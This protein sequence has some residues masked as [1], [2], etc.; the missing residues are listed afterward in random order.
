M[1]LP[2]SIVRAY[3]R[4]VPGAVDASQTYGGI[5]FPCNAKAP[6]FVFGVGAARIVIPAKIMAY[7]PVDRGSSMCFGGLQ[8]SGQLGV[9]IFGDTALKAAFV[10]FDASD[11]PAIGWA[12]KNLGF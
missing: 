6:P 11:P 9:N 3:Y 10:V 1:Y 12:A 4:Q 5:V 2:D 7:A 8:S